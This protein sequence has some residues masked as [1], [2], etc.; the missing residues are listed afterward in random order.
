MINQPSNN[1]DWIVITTLVIFLWYA[2]HCLNCSMRSKPTLELWKVSTWKI[3]TYGQKSFYT[4]SSWRNRRHPCCDVT[5]R[6]R[7]R[8]LAPLPARVFVTHSLR[9]TS[10]NAKWFCLCFLL[11]RFKWG[12]MALFHIE[13]VIICR[14]ERC[15]FTQSC[16]FHT[17]CT[18][19]SKR[20]LEPTGT[21]RYFLWPWH[22]TFC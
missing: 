14:K 22:S 6:G 9:K 13:C 21:L 19:Y 8:A 7:K 17:N 12:T 3:N 16:L 5:R 20:Q 15:W 18:L 1:D 2:Q 10:N 11:S 4:F